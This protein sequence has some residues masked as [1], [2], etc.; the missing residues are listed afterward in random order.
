MRVTVSK[1][2][3]VQNS[4]ALLFSFVTYAVIMQEV[5]ITKIA[6]R[7]NQPLTLEVLRSVLV[8]LNKIRVVAEEEYTE[9]S[10]CTQEV[11]RFQKKAAN[12]VTMSFPNLTELIYRQTFLTQSL[13]IT[14]NWDEFFNKI[15][16]S[17][18][19]E[20]LTALD[21]VR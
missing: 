11:M 16:L 13:L 1:S 21:K 4:I 3:R 19:K 14:L 6:Q 17:N 15:K 20:L 8:I 7:V 5:N 18:K 2:E 12:K 9:F 10:V